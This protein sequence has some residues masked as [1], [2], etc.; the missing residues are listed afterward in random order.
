MH[1]SCWKSTEKN[2]LINITFAHVPRKCA[3][4][5]REM[6]CD[7]QAPRPQ[8]P[9]AAKFNSAEAVGV[10]ISSAEVL[11][12][13]RGAS[14]ALRVE[15]ERR[16]G[17]SAGLKKGREASKREPPP[18]YYLLGACGHLPSSSSTPEQCLLFVFCKFPFGPPHKE[19]CGSASKATLEPVP[20]RCSPV[21][22]NEIC[23]RTFS[24]ALSF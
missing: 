4:V 20:L 24:T 1:E 23:W 11:H 9:Q 16:I 5:I 18:Y 12:I 7:S 17:P 2:H 19:R 14:C 21:C 15:D 6:A 13:R 3:I 10:F 8:W 22:G